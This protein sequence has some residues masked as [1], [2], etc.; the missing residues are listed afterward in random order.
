[1]NLILANGIS[2]AKAKAAIELSHR[3]SAQQRAVS[4]EL[5]VT[6]QTQKAE[7]RGA[8]DAP[9]GAPPLAHRYG[10]SPAYQPQFSESHAPLVKFF[11][12]NANDD[13]R[14]G[15][16]LCVCVHR[17]LN[18]PHTLTQTGSGGDGGGGGSVSVERVMHMQMSAK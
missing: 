1:M 13:E 16:S 3:R 9:P 5:S 10:S 8:D 12:T 4:N 18:S 11:A 2:C 15:W 6:A 14:M 7:R 17:Q